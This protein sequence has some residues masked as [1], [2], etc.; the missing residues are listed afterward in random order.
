MY[1]VSMAALIAMRVC[2]N[3]SR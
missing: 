1:F 2:W 3:A